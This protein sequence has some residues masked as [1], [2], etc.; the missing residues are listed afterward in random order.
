MN[1]DTTDLDQSDEET[2]AYEFSDE[3]LERAGNIA[4]ATLATCSWQTHWC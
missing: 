1:D 2:L 3:E 4:N